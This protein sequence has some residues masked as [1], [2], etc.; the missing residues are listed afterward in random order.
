[1]EACLVYDDPAACRD[2]Q[3]ECLKRCAVRAGLVRE[4]RDLAGTKQ[5]V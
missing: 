2:R 4:T 5:T 1:M 3:R